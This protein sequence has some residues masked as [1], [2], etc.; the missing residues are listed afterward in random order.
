MGIEESMGRCSYCTLG[1]CERCNGASALGACF[2]K[3]PK[4]E[5]GE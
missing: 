3:H 1:M 2:C 5:A 4:K